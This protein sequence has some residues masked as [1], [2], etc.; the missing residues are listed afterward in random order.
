MGM[1]VGVS[2]KGV[3]GTKLTLLRSYRSSSVVL[4]ERW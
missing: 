3:G 4:G 1:E 2:K